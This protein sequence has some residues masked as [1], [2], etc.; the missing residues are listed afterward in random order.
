MVHIPIQKAKDPHAI[1]DFSHFIQDA[2]AGLW[3]KEN[4]IM[5]HFIKIN[6]FVEGSFSVFSD[7]LLHLPTYGDVCVLSP[8]KMHYGQIEKEMHIDYYQFN[9]GLEAFS[10]I[11][12]G[13]QLTQRLQEITTHRDSFV[14][15]DPQSRENVLRLCRETEEAI[16]GDNYA[17]AYAKTVEFL[18]VLYPLYANPSGEVRTAF[19]YRIRQ[20]TD[21]IEAHYAEDLTR[22]RIAEALGISPSFLSRI[23][24]KELGVTVHEYLNRYRILKSLPLLACHSVTE[25]GYLCGFCD[26]SHFI[27]V[28]KK[29][30]GETPTCYIRRQ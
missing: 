7:N 2:P 5:H 8:L 29:H 25:T 10:A 15:P 3:K 24:K 30:M 11:P 19:S 26:T 12:D 21:Y 28:F 4:V 18:S 22:E 13:D 9:V 14:R 6:V 16:R 17:L 20:I 23:F 27:S 1:L